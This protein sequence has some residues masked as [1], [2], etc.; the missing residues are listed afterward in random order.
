MPHATA[1]KMRAKSI[2]LLV[3]I[4]GANLFPKMNTKNE[5]VFSQ[6]LKGNN[7]IFRFKFQRKQTQFSA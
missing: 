4:F 6:N 7:L 5:P 2:L 3:S 1:A